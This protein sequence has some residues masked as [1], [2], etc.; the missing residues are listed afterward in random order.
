MYLPVNVPMESMFKLK[1]SGGPRDLEVSMV[2]LKLGASVLQLGGRDG[3]LIAALAKV[4]GISGE[5][6]AV[7]ETA[8][9]ADGVQRAAGQ[10]GVLVDVKK[11]G[12]GALPFDADSFD[13][14]VV[15]DLI[16]ELRMN[17]RV[18]WL[19]DA[20]RV[21]KP[22]GRLVVIEAAQRGGLGSWFSQR[23]LDRTYLANGGARGA[24]EAEGFRGVRLLAERDGRSFVEGTK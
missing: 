22:N 1:K 20:L 7:V 9:E 8:E 4:V 17:A 3:Q 2:G 5:A 12:L 24:L 10:L 18:L 16:G 14:V 15:P 19:Q 13:A 23:S 6:C 21:L 11:A